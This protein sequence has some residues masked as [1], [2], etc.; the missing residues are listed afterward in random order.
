MSGFV[1]LCFFS[2][3]FGIFTRVLLVYSPYTNILNQKY[4]QDKQILISF[5]T[6][7]I[8]GLRNL[9]SQSS[10][11]CTIT[12]KTTFDHTEKRTNK[13]LSIFNGKLGRN[14]GSRTGCNS[15]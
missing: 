15:W 5:F 1:V 14:T 4:K 12:S 2:V 9:Q 13:F 11:T 6:L 8:T 10:V 3:S 7:F